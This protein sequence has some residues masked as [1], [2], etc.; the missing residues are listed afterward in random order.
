MRVRSG[1]AIQTGAVAMI[2]AFKTLWDVLGEAGRAV[3]GA[4]AFIIVTALIVN[5]HGKSKADSWMTCL[6]SVGCN[7]LVQSGQDND[8]APVGPPRVVVLNVSLP[9]GDNATPFITR[10]NTQLDDVRRRS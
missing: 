1:A 7:S 5:A 9:S 10:L 2:N 8:T 3:M 6:E 4:I